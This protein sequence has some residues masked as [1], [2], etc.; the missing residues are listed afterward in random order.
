[1][2]ITR[3]PIKAGSDYE[4][5]IGRNLLA[6]CGKYVKTVT[7][8][9]KTAVV[10]DDN[11]YGFYGE[12]VLQSLSENGFEVC[13]FVFP[14]G[15][16]SKTPD[17]LF[18]IWNFLAEHNITRSDCLIALGGGVTGDMT[19][20]A[21]ATYLRGMDFVQIP[22]TLLAQVDSSVGSKT[23]VDLAGGKNLV[24]AFKQPRLVLCDIDA[25]DT[26]PD[27]FFTDG[28]GEVVKHGMIKSAKLFE[29][30]EK[31]DLRSLRADRDVLAEVITQN[32][33]IKRDVVQAD[34]FDRGE[35]ML[36]NFGHT[37]GHS[38]EQYYNYTGITHGQAVA[39]GMK[40]ITRVAEAHGIAEPGVL[41]RLKKCLDSYGLNAEIEPSMGEL[42]AACLN[43]KKLFGD[44]IN[45]VVC[46]DVGASM[47]KK[48]HV[49]AFLAMLSE[50][51]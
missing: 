51:S 34:E 13:K 28:M 37:L 4:V 31:F 47:I 14:H 2:D 50:Q 7:K 19:G 21:A 30:L 25:L 20:F 16:Q 15:E 26:L 11:V 24:G 35:R 10:T 41:E 43:D 46:C 8:A 33:A 32:I 17:T 29:Q 44:T 42:G 3:I 36:L 40:M 12:K 49:E 18:Q 1:M 38:I 45:I 6:D 22:T 23:A 9:K 39:A 48:M 5:L 27:E